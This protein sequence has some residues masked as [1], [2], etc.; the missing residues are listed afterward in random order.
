VYFNDTVLDVKDAKRQAK[1]E[2]EMV[3]E[4]M[5]YHGRATPWDIV[6]DLGLPERKITNIRR[7]ITDLTVEGRLKKLEECAIGAHGRLNHYWTLNG[8]PYQTSL[9]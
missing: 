9:L 1:S 7:A 5:K 2:E 6:N 3:I 4:Y 8:N